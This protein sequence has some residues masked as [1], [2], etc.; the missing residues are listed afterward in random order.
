MVQD[1]KTHPNWQPI[2]TKRVQLSQLAR[3]SETAVVIMY[4]WGISAEMTH[5]FCLC[6]IAKTDTYLS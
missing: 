3:L 4:G 5:W 2:V 1:R 6:K